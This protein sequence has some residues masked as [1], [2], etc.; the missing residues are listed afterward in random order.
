MIL[1]FLFHPDHYTCESFLASIFSSSLIT[2]I[3]IGEAENIFK[4]SVNI[5]FEQVDFILK[6]AIL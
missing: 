4:Y 6:N 2:L 1:F 5:K 3:S